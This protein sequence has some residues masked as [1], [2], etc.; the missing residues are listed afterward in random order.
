MM[1]VSVQLLSLPLSPVGAG[2]E[3]SFIEMMHVSVQLLS[4]PLS[5]VGA[6]SENSFVARFGGAIC[7]KCRESNGGHVDVRVMYIFYKQKPDGSQVKSFFLQ[8]Q[9]SSWFVG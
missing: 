2:S 8:L 1:H 5:P 4:L 7:L 9:C 6:G 3:N